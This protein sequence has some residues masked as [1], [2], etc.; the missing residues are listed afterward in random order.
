MSKHD[1]LRG[2]FDWIQI[3]FLDTI[4]IDTIIED[5]LFMN[6]DYF[7]ED[8]GNLSYYK[9]EKYLT[10]GN[11]RIYFGRQENNFMLVMSGQTLEWYRENI[12][13]VYALSEKDFFRNLVTNFSHYSIRRIDVAIDDFNEKP[14][15]TPNDLL[16]I[17]QKKR[18][19]YGK[20]TYYLPYG[21]E[22]VGQTLYLRKPSDDERLRIYDKQAEQA[23]KQQVSKK[24]I[25]KWIRTELELRREKS[26]KFIFEFLES[27]DDILNFTK[28]YLKNRVKF[29][30]DSLFTIPYR[31][32]EV[33]LKNARPVNINFHKEDVALSKRFNWYA[34]KGSANV[35]KA[36]KFLWENNL[37]S[38]EELLNFE[39][40]D[41]VKYP[42]DLAS[43]L[44]ERAVKN[45]R[46]DLIPMIKKNIKRRD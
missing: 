42:P 44:I 9:Y 13:S 41:K 10:Y 27:K 20:S 30:E 28:G 19:I 33:F 3:Q 16:A 1:N 43:D 11:I 23:S 26:Q 12:L 14:F 46:E 22:N 40:L 17:C 2:I 24:E 37:L 15:F 34:N 36:Y 38:E 39:K 4:S 21:D 45:Q 8:K 31:N 29:Y 7:I 18:F 35:Y 5:I 6:S 32:W 25:Q